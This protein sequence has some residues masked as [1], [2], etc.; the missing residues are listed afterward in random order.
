LVQIKLNETKCTVKQ[1]K[2]TVL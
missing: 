1:W 2:E